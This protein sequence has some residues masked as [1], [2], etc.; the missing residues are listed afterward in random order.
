MRRKSYTKYLLPILSFFLLM[1]LPILFVEKMR[2]TAIA[3]FTPKGKAITPGSLVKDQ[4]VKRLEGENHL[5][6]MEIGKLKVLLEQQGAIDNFQKEAKG[7][8]SGNLLSRASESS[9]LLDLNTL[10]VPARVVYRDPAIW[11]SSIWVNVG[12]ETNKQLGHTV[13]AKNSPVGLGRSI[14]GALD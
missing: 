13:V 4:D 3:F 7:Y 6:R 14:V 1:S 11:R 2:A 5:L 12:E 9:F 10:S 8:S